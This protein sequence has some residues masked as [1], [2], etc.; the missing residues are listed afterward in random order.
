MSAEAC[1]IKHGFGDQRC[2]HPIGH[3]GTCRSHAYPNR[4][5]GTLT[6]S[7]WLSDDGRFRSHVAYHTTYP[8][9][10]Q[11]DHAEH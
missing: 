9:N 11:G 7:E 4:Q 1:N 6:W 10:A 2:I 3:E 5:D 8:R